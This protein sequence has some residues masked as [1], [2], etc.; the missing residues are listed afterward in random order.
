MTWQQLQWLAQHAASNR[1]QQSMDLLLQLLT[2]T[3]SVARH[4]VMCKQQELL[5]IPTWHAAAYA[6]KALRRRMH[7]LAKLKQAGSHKRS[8]S[9]HSSKMCLSSSSSSVTTSHGCQCWHAGPCLLRLQGAARLQRAA[10]AV[11]VVLTTLAGTVVL[12]E[13]GKQAAAAAATRVLRQLGSV[14]ILQAAQARRSKV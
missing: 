6:C 2:V 4:Q 1:C 11:A 7:L 12:Q 8:S 14:R 10:A 5:V 3:S 9:E 13:M